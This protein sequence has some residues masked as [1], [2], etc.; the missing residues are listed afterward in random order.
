MD[1]GGEAHDAPPICE[2]LLTIEGCYRRD[3]QFS[4]GMRALRGYR[5]L[6]DASL[7]NTNLSQHFVLFCYVLSGAYGVEK[8][9][10][11]G[12]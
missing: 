12:G 4:S 7:D 5:C 8:E 3:S 10:D 6:L 2:K 9:S 11:G 1:G